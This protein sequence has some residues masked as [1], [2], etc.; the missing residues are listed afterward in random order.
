MIDSLLQA[1]TGKAIL[2]LPILV[3]A[4]LVGTVNA[5]LS[6]TLFHH[7]WKSYSDEYW[8]LDAIE[9]REHAILSKEAADLINAKRLILASALPLCL[10]GTGW[11]LSRNVWGPDYAT[12]RSIGGILGIIAGLSAPLFAIIVHL[13]LRAMHKS[14]KQECPETSVPPSGG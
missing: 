9:R 1:E 7:F 11:L 14:L 8:I 4:Y 6:G 3:T 2:G 12:I 13:S 5:I 10:V